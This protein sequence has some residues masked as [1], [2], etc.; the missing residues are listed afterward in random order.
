MSPKRGWKLIPINA[1]TKF[2]LITDRMKFRNPFKFV[3]LLTFIIGIT[4]LADASSYNTTSA[5]STMHN[6]TTTTTMHNATTTLTTLNSTTMMPPYTMTTTTTIGTHVPRCRTIIICEDENIQFGNIM[7]NAGNNLV[8]NFGSTEFTSTQVGIAAFTS[9]TATDSV[10]TTIVTTTSSTA[11]T[12]TN[13]PNSAA[14]SR[15]TAGSLLA[16]MLV[17]IASIMI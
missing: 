9:E 13:T 15:K 17:I 14:S 3:V 11:S 8:Y 7:V 10:T 4:V 16:L 2:S 5:S 6:V 1:L 12:T